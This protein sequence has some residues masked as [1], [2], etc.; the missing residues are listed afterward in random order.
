MPSLQ[1]AYLAQLSFGAREL[2]AI[3]RL[4]EAR[5]RQDL[6]LRQY[7]EQLDTLRKRGEEI[8]EERI[9]HVEDEWREL[10]GLVRAEMEKG[11]DPA[12]PS[13]Q[14]L[15][16]RWMGLVREFTGGD[17]GIAKSVAKVYRSE[18]DLHKRLDCVPTPEMMEYMMKAIGPENLF[19]TR[20]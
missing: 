8:G 13:V 1:P 17:P 10:I 3:H 19:P 6:F 11:S 5:G 18:P 20:A 12:S 9:R 15:A 4:G 7:P 2:A 14:E 16:K